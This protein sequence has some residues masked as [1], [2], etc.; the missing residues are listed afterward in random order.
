MSREGMATRDVTN[1]ESIG[2][3]GWPGVGGERKGVNRSTLGAPFSTPCINL[4]FEAQPLPLFLWDCFTP[5]QFTDGCRTIQSLLFLPW[6][7]ELDPTAKSSLPLRCWLWLSSSM[8]TGKL[9]KLLYSKREKESRS[10][11]EKDERWRIRARTGFP[12]T[13]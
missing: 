13:L 5:S 7:P 4:V 1:D 2:L 9:K 12:V 10:E 8:W 11:R 6:N 3:A